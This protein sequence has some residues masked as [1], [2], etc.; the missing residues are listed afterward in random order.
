M[1]VDKCTT[2]GKDG[3]VY[4]RALIRDSYRE[5][6]KVKHR[7]IAN[8]SK[9]SQEEIRAIEFALKNKNRLTDI[10]SGQ[11]HHEMAQ[12]MSVGAVIALYQVARELGIL[13]VLGNSEMAKLA[14]WMIFAR[15]IEPGSRLANVR[16]AQ[17]HSAADVIG[18]DSFN[19]DDLYAALDWAASN[20]KAIEKK[21]FRF[22]GV[23]NSN[24]LYLY[25]ITSSY[26]EG[27]KNELAMW[28]YDRDKKKGKMQ[29]VIGLLTDAQGWPVAIEVFQ[30]NT[31][32][33]RTVVNQLKKLAC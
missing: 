18:M 29:I 24:S 32:D 16:L 31:Q 9:C 30:G 22:R 12:G 15:L 10:L 28:G 3:K 23:S 19:E 27:T 5:N 25:D 14:L 2:K 33:P 20:Q 6:G 11:D 13:K 1:F 21:L 26:L 17:S 8:I 7:T 4:F